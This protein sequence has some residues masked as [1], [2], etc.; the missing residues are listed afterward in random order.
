MFSYWFVTIYL[1][2]LFYSS[3]GISNGRQ[4]RERTCI[5]KWEHNHKGD[6]RTF[7]KIGEGYN[8]E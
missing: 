3:R 1:F 5:F 6:K 2:L 8:G 7:Q 4:L